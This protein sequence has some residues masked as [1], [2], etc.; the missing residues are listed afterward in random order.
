MAMLGGFFSGLPQDG[1]GRLDDA[2]N[3]LNTEGGLNQ[4]LRKHMEQGGVLDDL[5]SGLD[6]FRGRL[7]LPSKG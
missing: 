3:A 5:T 4:T 2:L 7:G 1:D 6:G